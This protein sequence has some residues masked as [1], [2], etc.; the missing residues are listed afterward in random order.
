M[1]AA[2]IQR[3][4]KTKTGNKVSTARTSAIL[5]PAIAYGSNQ[6]RS[7]RLRQYR[8]DPASVLG[9][10]AEAIDLLVVVRVFRHPHPYP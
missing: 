6:L 8:L 9:V 3:C 7:I 10:Q 5:G 4:K 2:D 1:E